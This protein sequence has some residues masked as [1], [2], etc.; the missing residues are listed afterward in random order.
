MPSYIDKKTLDCESFTECTKKC[1]HYN[2]CL[3]EF[4]IGKQMDN[5]PSMIS[6][7]IRNFDIYEPESNNTKDNFIV[8]ICEVPVVLIN[9]ALISQF[10]SKEDIQIKNIISAALNKFITVGDFTN[11]TIIKYDDMKYHFVFNCDDCN[12]LNDFVDYATDNSN[13][14][15]YCRYCGKKHRLDLTKA[16]D[17][18]KGE[19]NE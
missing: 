11:A 2:E 15:F 19:S 17:K 13:I 14:F 12:S 4:K 18:S 3:A 8:N 16:I 7:E 5:N 10:D 6:A 1:P 9:K